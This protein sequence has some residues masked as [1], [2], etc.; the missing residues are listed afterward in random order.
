MSTTKLAHLKRRSV[1]RVS[2][3]EAAKLLDGLIT[4]SLDRLD[5]QPAI[6]TGL[7]SPQGKILFDFFVTRAGDDLLIDTTAGHTADL[8]TRLTF[9]RLRAEVTFEDLSD[10]LIVVAAWHSDQPSVPGGVIAVPDPRHAALGHRLILPHER[11]AELP[12]EHTDEAAY[13]A[14]RIQVGVPEAGADYALGDTFPHEAL[15][16]QLH[17]VDF[18][19]GCFVGQ[20]VVSR[21]QHRGTARKRIVPVEGQAPLAATAEVIAGTATIGSLGSVSANRGLALLRLDR[22]NEAKAKGEQIVA[23]DVTVVIAQPDWL[24]LDI[25]TGKSEDRS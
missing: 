13:D 7:L 9:Y 15:Y 1:I 5:T 11:L 17:S 25:A 23:G 14:H 18:A 22:A 6:H 20:E 3:P 24:A 4:N 10:Q 2:G 12:G 19:K 16:D 21:M 8:I